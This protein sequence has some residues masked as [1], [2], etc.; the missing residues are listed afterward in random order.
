MNYPSFD[1][2]IAAFETLTELTPEAMITLWQAQADYV[3]DLLV[4]YRDPAAWRDDT[5]D[6]LPDAIILAASMFGEACEGPMTT[7]EKL[8]IHIAH[9]GIDVVPWEVMGLLFNTYDEMTELAD[10]TQD[11]LTDHWEAGV[12]SHTTITD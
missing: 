2:R 3:R 1:D 8:R 7:L 5:I 4:E 6:T 11:R 9:A 12:I 10:R